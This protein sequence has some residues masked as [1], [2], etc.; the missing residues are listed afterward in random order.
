M[1]TEEQVAHFETFGFLV[2]QRL[3]SA[4]EVA[5]IRKETDEIFDEAG[6]GKP[7]TG[8]MEIIHPYLRAAALHGG[9]CG[10]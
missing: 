1:L 7:Y 6:G 4:Q 5:T 8:E 10:R 3:F 9:A 2:L